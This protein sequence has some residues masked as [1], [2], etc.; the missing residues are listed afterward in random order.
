MTANAQWKLQSENDTNTYY[1]DYSRIKTEGKYKSMWYLNNQKSPQTNS[2]GQQ[3]KSTMS[4]I[5]IDCQASRMQQVA[6][7]NYSEQMGDGVI[8]W[9]NSRSLQESEWGAVNKFV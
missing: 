7:F 9:S 4:K 3:Y 6:L 2:S 5:I 1:I 8:I